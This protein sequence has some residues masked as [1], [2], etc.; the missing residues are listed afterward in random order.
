MDGEPST[1]SA[2]EKSVRILK[3]V[4]A[5]QSVRPVGRDI[6]KGTVVLRAGE[7]L[8]AAEVRKTL[9]SRGGLPRGDGRFC[10]L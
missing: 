4:R 3:G 2:D 9:V 1:F 5:G 7:K 10:R 8:L 6:T